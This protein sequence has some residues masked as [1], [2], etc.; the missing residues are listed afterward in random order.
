MANCTYCKSIQECLLAE[1]RHGDDLRQRFIE[2][3]RQRDEARALLREASAAIEEEAN[4]YGWGGGVNEPEDAAW[5][6]VS[7]LLD[8]IDA[9]L[10][11]AKEG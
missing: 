11:G 1:Q 4:E 7:S 9:A 2:A 6:R 10:S 5:G 3:E 8:R